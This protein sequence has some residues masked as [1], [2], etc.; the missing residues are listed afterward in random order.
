MLTIQSKI[1]VYVF[2]LIANINLPTKLH[3]QINASINF[4]NIQNKYLFN[5]YDFN[6][7]C[8]SNDI[9]DSTSSNSL[10]LD[11]G[12]GRAPKIFEGKGTSAGIFI[13]Y[14]I[15]NYVF[16][17]RSMGNMEYF[18]KAGPKPVEV[19]SDLSLLWGYKLLSNRYHSI[20]PLI[21]AGKATS[22]KRGKLLSEFS[23]DAKHETLTES[24]IGMSLGIKFQVHTKHTA[25]SL[26]V[27]SSVN[28]IQS[29]YGV[30]FCFGL[31][32]IY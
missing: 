15:K 28:S 4:T 19:Y 27:F 8:Q 5:S 25:Y 3:C 11:I 16:S 7:F 24:T 32:R 9:V 22:I 1:I 10:F 26:Y 17:L 30:L 2:I 31:G 20:I 14:S 23:V 6:F 18:L 13:Y 29:Y 21:G 12:L